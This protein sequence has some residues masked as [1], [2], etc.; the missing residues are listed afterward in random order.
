MKIKMEIYLFLDLETLLF[1]F[2]LLSIKRF[3]SFPMLDHYHQIRD[4]MSYE[5]ITYILTGF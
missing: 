2:F 3:L 4:S 5:L 1:F